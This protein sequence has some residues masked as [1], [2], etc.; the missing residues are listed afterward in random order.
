M[1]ASWREYVNER[2]FRASVFNPHCITHWVLDND[3]LNATSLIFFIETKEKY[4]DFSFNVMG[5]IGRSHADTQDN[6]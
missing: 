2:K 1:K 5:S 4:S 6:F 3:K